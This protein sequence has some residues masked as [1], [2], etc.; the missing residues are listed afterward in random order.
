LSRSKVRRS[1]RITA[2]ELNRREDVLLSR[3]EECRLRAQQLDEQMQDLL[4]REDEAAAKLSQL[5]KREAQNALSQLE[6][7][8]TCALY[9]NY[10]QQL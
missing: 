7:H 8:F 5:A 9:V 10:D 4:D 6:E 3:E 1:S 2:S